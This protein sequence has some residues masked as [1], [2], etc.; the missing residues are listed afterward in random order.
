[1]TFSQ[2]VINRD[3]MTRIEEFFGADRTDI[4]SAAGDKNVHAL[5]VKDKER[6]KSSK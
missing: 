6:G 5:I 1:M 2:V 4:T 3:L